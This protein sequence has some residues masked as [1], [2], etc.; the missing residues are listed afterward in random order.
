MMSL[1]PVWGLRSDFLI[2]RRFSWRPDQVVQSLAVG[3]SGIARPE[4][5]GERAGLGAA[6]E[7][8]CCLNPNHFAFLAEC[9]VRMR[10]RVL[11]HQRERPGGIRATRGLSLTQDLDLASERR[12]TRAGRSG[13]DRDSGRRRRGRHFGCSSTGRR[14]CRCRRRRSDLRARCSRGRRGRQGRSV[15][16]TQFEIC[17]AG[18]ERDRNHGPELGQRGSAR[19]RSGRSGSRRA[20]RQRC[21]HA[22]DRTERR[23]QA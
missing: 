4:L 22:L 6:S 20:D 15:L 14:W 8:G 3:R 10:A 5:L 21:K 16:A 17:S 7:R 12:R 2:S 1:P 11:G 23:H 19:T 18:C 9:S 13:L